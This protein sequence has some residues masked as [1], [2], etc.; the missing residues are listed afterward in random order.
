MDRFRAAKLYV[1][2]DGDELIIEN[3]ITPFPISAKVL[4]KRLDLF[5]NKVQRRIRSLEKTYEEALYLYSGSK[6]GED[7]LALNEDAAFLAIGAQ[8]SGTM[9]GIDYRLVTNNN[10]QQLEPVTSTFHGL[11]P[12]LL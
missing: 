7:F 6:I 8:D 1:E 5:Q 4:S 2:K 12:I 10:Q 9:A 3:Y 11:N